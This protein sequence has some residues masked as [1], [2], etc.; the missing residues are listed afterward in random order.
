M[1]DQL[2]P[3]ELTETTPRITD[4]PQLPETAGDGTPRPPAPV[5]PLVMVGLALVLLAPV[6]MGLFGGKSFIALLCMLLIISGGI[7]CGFGWRAITNSDGRQRGARLAAAGLLLGLL[8]ISLLFL[9]SRLHGTI[10]RGN[11]ITNQKEISLALTMYAQDYG[12]FPPDWKTAQDYTNKTL[13]ESIGPA[14]WVCDARN[15]LDPRPAHGGYGM[16]AALAGV[17]PL[18]ITEPATL[19]LTGDAHTPDGLI[20]FS[21][22]EKTGYDVSR[23]LD[24]NRHGGTCVVSYADGSARAVPRQVPVRID[25]SR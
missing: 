21:K 4:V 1:T 25:P 16:N 20:R 8:F 13:T 2:E 24:R 15:W 10:A 6:A 11:C 18:K 9:I 19:L 3:T 22:D 12:V 14:L 7:T 23:E 5:S 17:S